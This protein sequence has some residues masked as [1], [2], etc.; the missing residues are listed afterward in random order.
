MC[1]RVCIKQATD[2]DE[3]NGPMLLFN[4]NTSDNDKNDDTFTGF[5][6]GPIYQAVSSPQIKMCVLL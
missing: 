6:S 4:G 1:V 5:N 3:G 2:Q